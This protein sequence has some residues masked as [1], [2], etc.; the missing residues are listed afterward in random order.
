MATIIKSGIYASQDSRAGGAPGTLVQRNAKFAHIRIEGN[1]AA[2]TYSAYAVKLPV[3]AT[4]LPQA[5]VLRADS[6]TTVT[7]VSIGTPTA[8]AK[9]VA[10]VS[11]PSLPV[12]GFTAVVASSGAALVEGDT[13]VVLTFT[14]AANAKF[15]LTLLLAYI[16]ATP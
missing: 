11:S 7:A 10:A 4:V 16:D 2:D 13:D 8:S 6:G 9:F 5:S 15:G 1:L 3:G 12:N 14:T